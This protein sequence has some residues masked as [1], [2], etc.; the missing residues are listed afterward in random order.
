MQNRKTIE[1]LREMCNNSTRFSREERSAILQAIG[2]M[3]IRVAKKP[4]LE[5]DGYDDNGEL[6][7]DTG[8]CPGCRHE[9]EV[10]YDSPKH[11]PNCGQALDWSDTE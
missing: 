5:G 4:D 10:Y 11:C 7:Y 6:I 8:Y 1:L 9:F 3:N 2:A